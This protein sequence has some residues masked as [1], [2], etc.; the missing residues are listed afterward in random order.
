MAWWGHTA[1]RSISLSS[2]AQETK[3]RTRFEAALN[4]DKSTG[5]EA[6]TVFGTV[7]MDESGWNRTLSVQLSHQPN[8]YTLFAAVAEVFSPVN[9]G[10]VV[11][12]DVKLN[13]QFQPAAERIGFPTSTANHRGS[14]DDLG[15]VAVGSFQ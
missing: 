2:I 13:I 4:L 15:P 14:N 1:M 3:K 12:A 9:G 6:R 7:R 5:G 10:D 8:P 11:T